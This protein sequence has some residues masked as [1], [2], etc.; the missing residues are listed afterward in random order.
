MVI[1][2]NGDLIVDSNVQPPGFDLRRH[3]SVLLNRCRHSYEKSSHP[4]ETLSLGQLS[5]TI[6]G[7]AKNFFKLS[8][9]TPYLL[10]TSTPLM[11]IF[12]IW[13]YDLFTT[14]IIFVQIKIESGKS[15]QINNFFQLFFRNNFIHGVL[16]SVVYSNK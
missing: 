8:I 3:N 1:L 7:V 15:L 14:P 13:S 16:I 10:S 9:S 4:C 11:I 5:I 2:V 12:R 6:Y